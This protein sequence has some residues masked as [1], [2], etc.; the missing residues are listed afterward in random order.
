MGSRFSYSKLNTYDGCGF[1]Y[2]LTYVDGHYTFTDSVASEFGTLVHFIEESIARNLK[3]SKPIDYDKLKDEFQ[4]IDIPKKDKFDTEGGI[5]GINILKKKYPDEFYATDEN[6]VSYHTKA[7]D[8]LDYGIHRLENRLKANP[9]YR[10]FDMEKFFSVEYKGHTLSGFI[11]RIIYDR[12]KDRYII[13]DIKT[14][15]KPFKE[16]ALVTPLQFVI[17]AIA[18]SESI[19]ISED[20]ID[21]AYDLPFLDMRQSA[22]SPGFIA[23]GRRK[24]DSIFDGIEGREYQPHQSPLCF[25]CPYCHN[26][27]AAPSDAKDLCPYYSKWTRETRSRSVQNR[28]EGLDRHDAVMA[29]FKKQI[30]DEG[31]PAAESG[32]DGALFF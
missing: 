5:F 6:G 7:L 1:K 20:R 12:E 25:W 30:S 32:S 17:Y 11:D 3:E 27:P 15:G 10:I 4:N 24:L 21:C 16:D 14:K 26:N 19:G 9:S 13:E 2:K 18:L 8:Y 22:G 29:R 23:R 31:A 28:W